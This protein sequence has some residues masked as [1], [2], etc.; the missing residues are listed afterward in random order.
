[1]DLGFVLHPGQARARELFEEAKAFV[2]VAGWSARELETDGE[3]PGELDAVVSLGGDGTMLRA[4]A[5]AWHRDVPVLGVNLGQLGYLAE[6]EPA[7]LPHALEALMAGAVRIEERVAVRVARLG[8][9]E[10]RVGFN[11]VVVERR[12]SGHLI[13]ADVAIAGRS[14]L[15]YAADGIIVATPTGSTA[16]AFS[17]RGPVLSPRVEALVLTPLAPHQ[18]FDRSLVLALDEPVEVRLLDGP[19][20]SV[21]VDGVPWSVLRPG[22]AVVIRSD[23]RRVRLAQ[24]DAP[25]FHEVLKAKFG[26]EANDAR[27]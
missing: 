5:V 6:V 25:P 4:M 10:E 2:G 16:Y 8:S 1:M 13:R 20:A 17:A 21:M 27:C 14:F 24:V 11:E 26:L 7:A 22:E 3:D 23:E 12:V 19:E 9:V 18:L 15:R